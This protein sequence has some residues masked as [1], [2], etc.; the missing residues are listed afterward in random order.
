MREAQSVPSL[1]AR[2]LAP[3]GVYAWQTMSLQDP[4]LALENMRQLLSSGENPWVLVYRDNL[5]R[6]WSL[7][8]AGMY[9]GR[10]NARSGLF[11]IRTMMRQGMLI[12]HLKSR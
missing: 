12:R 9:P 11:S 2:R 8:M 3:D 7:L 5:D 10:E 4:Y 1:P 6:Q